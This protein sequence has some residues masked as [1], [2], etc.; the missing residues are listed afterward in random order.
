MVLHD[1]LYL[2]I[3]DLIFHH[4]WAALVTSTKEL[5]SVSM[6]AYATDAR[7][8]GLLLFLSQLAPHT[9]Q[10]IKN[11]VCCLGVSQGDDGV[12][13]PQTLSRI[14][15]NGQ[16]S[17]VARDDSRFDEWKQ[18]YCKRLPASERLFG[19]ADFSLFLF[20]PEH[21]RYVGGFGQAHNL[22]TQQISECFQCAQRLAN[23]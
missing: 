7:E 10:L 15:L 5:P 16:V 21:G 18:V 2:D 19:F 1:D 8:M 6:V 20:R 23:E 11:P 3:A 9:R 22:T 17:R 4:R 13:D 12:V 14:S